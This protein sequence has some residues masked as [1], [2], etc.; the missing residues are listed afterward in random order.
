MLTTM[1]PTIQLLP[2]PDPDIQ[3]FSG[4]NQLNTMNKLRF[5]VSEKID[6]VYAN[7]YSKLSNVPRYDRLIQ[8]KSGN[9]R[10]GEWYYG[11]QVWMMNNLQHD[12]K[13]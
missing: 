4:Y 2:T 3:Y 7:H 11:P 13:K 5:R 6:V 10:Y 12:L 1:E 8:Y 9:L